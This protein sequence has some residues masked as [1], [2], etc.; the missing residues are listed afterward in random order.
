MPRGATAEVGAERW[1]PNGYHYKKTEND[2]WQLSHRLI[3]EEKLGRKLAENEYA[4]FLDG[5]KTNLDPENIIVRTRGRQ[6]LKRRIAQVEARLTELTATRDD[7][8]ERLRI[9]ESLDYKESEL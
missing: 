5:D 7:L 4:T 3:A 9:Q 6:S 1:S 2:G 8:L